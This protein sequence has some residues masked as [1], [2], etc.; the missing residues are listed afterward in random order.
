MSA[1][2]LATKLYLPPIRP[3]LVI[4]P[5]LLRRLDEGLH[6]KL[7][8]LSA[9]AGF[10][11]TTLLADWAAGLSGRAQVA[12]LTID[13]ADNDPRRFL[14]YF[15]AA[16]QNAYPHVAESMLAPPDFLRPGFEPLLAGLL[17]ELKETSSPVVLVLDDYHL[18]DEQA[19]HQ[20]IDFLLDHQPAQF[21][22]VLA[23]RAD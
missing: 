14:E 9:P 17:N 3:G 2:L 4:R 13:Q 22:L 10:G 7:T 23:T 5:R 20:A 11:K 16:L 15:I 12:W 18:I 1:H 6:C 8:L 19:I 21:H